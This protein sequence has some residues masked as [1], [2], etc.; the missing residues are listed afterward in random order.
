ML[1]KPYVTLFAV[2]CYLC[3]YAVAKDT[4]PYLR[5]V[6]YNQESGLSGN[7]IRGLLQ[8]FRGY[9]WIATSSGL[10][11]F[12]GYT[13]HQYFSDFEDSST[14]SDDNAWVLYEDRQQRLWAGTSKGLDLYDRQKDVFHS[15]YPVDEEGKSRELYVSAIFEDSRNRFYIGTSN[16]LYLFDRSNLLYEKVPD[17]IAGPVQIGSW[18][19]SIY[20]D[21]RGWIWVGTKTEGIYA[22][23]ADGIL[24]YKHQ[25]HQPST[26]SDWIVDIFQ[27]QHQRIWVRTRNSF[28]LLD[29]ESGKFRRHRILP[30]KDFSS[31]NREVVNIYNV[32]ADR[33]RV[34]T[35][36]SSNK[37]DSDTFTVQKYLPHAFKRFARTLIDREG[38]L[39]TGSANNGVYYVN[40]IQFKTNY[41]SLKHQGRTVGANCFFERKDGLIWVG[42]GAGLYLYDRSDHLAHFILP[43]AIQDV[44]EDQNNTV[45]VALM[46]ECLIK[47]NAEEYY[48]PQVKRYHPNPANSGALYSNHFTKIIEDCKGNLWV[49]L[50]DAL[51][52]YEPKQDVFTCYFYDPTDSMSLSSSWVWSLHEEACEQLWIA[53]NDGL[54]RYDYLHD[55]FIR[56]LTGDPSY[57]PYEDFIWSITGDGF[58]DLWLAT[59]NGLQLFSPEGGV[60]KSWQSHAGL[61]GRT[62]SE[63][64]EDVKGRLWLMINQGLSCLDPVSG[65]IQNYGPREGLI[66][67]FTYNGSLSAADGTL[68]FNAPGGFIYFNPD[69]IFQVGEVVPPMVFTD[70]RVKNHKIAIRPDRKPLEGNSPYLE[71]S[72]EELEQVLLPAAEKDFSI[73]F[74]A[75][76][77]LSPKQNEYQYRLLGYQNDWNNT[78]AENRTISY[79][80]LSPGNFT[81][82]ARGRNSG[83][84]WS[85]PI[86]MSITILP[87]WSQTWCLYGLVC[88]TIGYLIY[89]QLKNQWLLETQMQ[90]EHVKAERLQ[91]LQDFQKHFFTN[92]T[93]EFRTPL[94][95]ILGMVEQIEKAPRKW[96]DRGLRLIQRSGKDLLQLVN[97]MLDL[98]KLVQKRI[99][100]SNAHFVARRTHCLDRLAYTHF[101]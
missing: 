83:G 86:E 41:F 11:K 81:F 60:I 65:K 14:I 29:R 10:N 44:F 37:A 13:F 24:Q 85:E 25:Y 56:F 67:N 91:A 43:G 90:I 53:T 89:R 8:D 71:R 38:G 80:N 50:Y 20:E 3:S 64:I 84:N 100:L 36:T 47:F 15:F 19:Q 5:P 32:N 45:W 12:D 74:S 69:S 46:D 98:S 39:W 99:I 101:I 73:T 77:Y 27:D 4:K 70:F 93:H 97:Q 76:S 51:C 78:T 6:I 68:F 94:T 95:I 66:N 79:T 31:D 49:G 63:V 33:F 2:A 22:I 23:T 28:D 58:G 16:G 7:F 61:P 26:G 87:P 82:Q 9:I 62:V 72:L 30:M 1:K 17:A 57:G 40:P 75:L 34:V 88:L 21:H 96:L 18:V 52:R 55:H 59:K 48:Q 42:S 54:N 92:I 35:V